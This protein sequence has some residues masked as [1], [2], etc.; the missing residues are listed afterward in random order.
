MSLE[1]ESENFNYLC[2]LTV[3]MVEITKKIKLNKLQ[4]FTNFD[5]YNLV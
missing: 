1:F 2:F 4:I 5:Y 3:V